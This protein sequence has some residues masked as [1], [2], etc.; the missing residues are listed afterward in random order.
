MGPE[1]AAVVMN[2]FPPVGWGDVATKADLLVVRTEL[3]ADLTERINDLQRT[4][5]FGMIA[6]NATLAGLVFAVARL[7]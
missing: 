6:T 2:M 3:R 5:F 4:L 7:A 1:K